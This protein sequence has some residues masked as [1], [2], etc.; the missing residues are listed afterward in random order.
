MAG[1]R[2]QLSAYAVG[3]R[4]PD[5]RLGIT[6]AIEAE[7]IGLGGIWAS[8]RWET[9]ETGALCGAIVQATSK[10]R[11]VA[12][13]THFTGRHPLVVAG[14]GS[15]LQ[16]LSGNRF[17]MGIG[18]SIPR[19]L[20]ERG[21]PVFN[22]AHMREYVDILRRLWAGETVSY[23]GIL[24]EYPRLELNQLPDSA[25]PLILGA[26]GPKTLALGGEAFDG[27]VLHPFLTPDGVRRSCAIIRDAAQKVGRNPKDVKVTACVVTAADTLTA[28]EKAS[29]LDARAVSYFAFRELARPIIEINHWDPAGADKLVASE[30]TRVEHQKGNAEDL[31]QKLAAQV[32]L[33]PHEWL[34]TGAA[35]GSVEDCAARLHDYRLAGADEILI[36]G[37]T[38]DRLEPIA[39]SYMNLADQ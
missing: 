9:K 15:T 14:M 37:M 12:G 31:R 4:A 3:G 8:E 25:P 5:P 34:N 21:L 1:N 30:L 10:I 18:R 23:D 28:S 33:L 2:G 38:P 32:S 7:R 16:M 24:G 6:H 36:H 17:A 19:N 35:I 26:V 29:V 27:V 20:K 11:V 39:N 13:L 22:S